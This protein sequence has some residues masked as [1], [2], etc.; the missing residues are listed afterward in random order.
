MTPGTPKNILPWK[1]T[2]CPWKWMVGRLLSFS[3]VPFSGDMLVSGRVPSKHLSP[4]LRYEYLD[5]YSDELPM[6][7][8]LLCFAHFC[9]GSVYYLHPSK[10]THMEPE[11][12]VLSFFQEREQF[13]QSKERQLPGSQIFASKLDDIWPKPENRRCG[14]TSKNRFF[15]GLFLQ[16]QSQMI[17]TG[18]KKWDFQPVK[19]LQNLLY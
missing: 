6:V 9:W 13:I 7:M 18:T 16:F 4:Q 3:E 5:V 19:G 8:I 11:K 17:C 12:M 15:T 10:A 2:V 14:C 1:L